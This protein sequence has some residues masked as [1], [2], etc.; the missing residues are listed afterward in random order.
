MRVPARDAQ[1]V[2]ADAELGGVRLD[3]FDDLFGSGT[4]T[5]AHSSMNCTMR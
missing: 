2:V 3:P 4:S 1:H 5:S